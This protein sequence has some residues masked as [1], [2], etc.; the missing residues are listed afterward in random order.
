MLVLRIFQHKRKSVVAVGAGLAC[1]WCGFS[2]TNASRYTCRLLV[3]VVWRAG[4]VDF[5]TQ[6]QVDGLLVV[7]A[8]RA[9]GVNIPTQTHV[10]GLRCVCAVTY[11]PS[12][13]Q[14]QIHV[15]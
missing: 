5:P 1:W 2:N 13:L 10:S 6:T 9:G 8:W 14:L 15:E 12:Y 11:A 7:I 4:G 3:V